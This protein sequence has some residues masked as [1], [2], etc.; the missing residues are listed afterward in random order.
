M[1]NILGGTIVKHVLNYGLAFFDDLDIDQ[2][3]FFPE[4]ISLVLIYLSMPLSGD[5]VVLD[6]AGRVQLHGQRVRLC[7]RVGVCRLAHVQGILG[8]VDFWEGTSISKI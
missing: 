2:N 5:E 8:Q 3:L 4:I 6:F 1:Y 7:L